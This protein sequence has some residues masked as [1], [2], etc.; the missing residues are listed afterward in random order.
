MEKSDK[1]FL[2]VDLPRFDFPVVF[3]EQV[4]LARSFLI[5]FLDSRE[6]THRVC[7][8]QHYLFHLARYLIPL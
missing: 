1:L 7:R 3:A 8:K 6:L 4:S 5:L 2:Y